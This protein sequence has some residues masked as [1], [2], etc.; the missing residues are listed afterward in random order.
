MSA[1]TLFVSLG[2]MTSFTFGLGSVAGYMLGVHSTHDLTALIQSYKPQHDNEIEDARDEEI[3]SIKHNTDPNAGETDDG[4]DIPLKTTI[5]WN[6]GLDSGVP[7]GATTPVKCA[8]T[9]R[10]VLDTLRADS[11]SA[12]SPSK[13]SNVSSHVSPSLELNGPT[14]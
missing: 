4:P 13:S 2:M 6:G 14:R 12:R 10:V 11:I 3:Q 8:L 7:S 1:R 5:T 9:P